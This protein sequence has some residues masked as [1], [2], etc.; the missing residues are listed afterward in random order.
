ML[1][2]PVHVERPHLLRQPVDDL[3]TRQITLVHGAIEALPREGFLM[4]R[5]IRVAVEIASIFVFQL[6]DAFHGTVDECPGEVLVRQPFAADNRVHEMTLDG[7]ARGD[8]N[9]IAAL[10]H[11][12]APRFA[13]ETLDREGDVEIRVRL[14]RVQRGKQAGAA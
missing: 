13:N 1:F 11:A 9:V 10:N 8:G 4:Q 7:V 12:R 6:V 2:Q 3:D 14:R 5:S